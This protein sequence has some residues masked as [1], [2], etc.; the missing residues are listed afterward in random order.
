MILLI[1]NYDSFTYNLYQYIGEL[2]KDIQV[3]RNDEITLDEIEA[4]APQALI[5]SPGPG[6]PKDAGITMEAIR[7][8]S[9]KFPILGVCLGHQS[10]CEAFGGTIVR[11]NVL[12]H[13]KSSR[14]NLDVTC[15]L[16]QGLPQ[17]VPCGRYHSLICQE[18]DF[19][20]CLKVTGRDEDGQ[21]MALAHR[22]H[23]TY[24]VQFHPES[25][26]TEDGKRML[27]N[28]LNLIPGVSVPLPAIKEEK[29]KTELKKY[30]AKVVDGNDLTEQEAAE[31]MDIIM[32]GNATNAQIAAL[33]TALRMK[34]ETI[35]EITGFAKGMR[36]KALHVNG[37]EESIDIV[38]TG[39][40]LA[41][42][43]NIST[44]SSF[45]IAAAGMPVAK[46][47][48]RSVSSKSGAADV[49]ESLGV[50][51]QTTPEQA[52]ACVEHVG[53]SFLFAQNYHGSMKYVAP[54]RKELGLRTVFNV[55]GPLTNPASTNY[56]VLGVYDK[57]LLPVMAHVLLGL[58]IKRA[59]IIYGN[60][61][62]DEISISDKTSVAEVRDG[63]VTEYEIAPEDFGLPRGTKEEI[64]GGIADE[65]ARITRGILDGSI[66]DARRNIVLMNAGCALYISGKAE[67]I[68]D[69]I[70]LAAEQIDSGRALEKLQELVR[71]TN[72]NA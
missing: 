41:N 35:P 8:F 10:I 67:T 58:G 16:F 23:P 70:A 48:N 1:D 4:M 68:A 66:Q 37:C 62:L 64:V 19:P 51:I 22:E 9:G 52:K 20:E 63:T 31:A 30:A 50:K 40:D 5:F 29:L 45:V 71:F 39:G 6:Y 46:H 54:V 7:R 3:V 12:M 44:T 38:G 42:S 69:G 59:M 17:S 53:I 57:A 14:I 32:S 65:N 26:L 33:L 36:Q 47:G 55:L 15:P 56:I 49:L 34:G 27:A 28:F 43:F 60:D 72:Q 18:S 2:Y 13:G 61:R 25:L 21:I 11:A 24:G